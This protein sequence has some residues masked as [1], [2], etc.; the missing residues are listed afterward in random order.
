MA[1]IQEP[2]DSFERCHNPE[3]VPESVCVLCL[4]T[5]VAPTVEVLGQLGTPTRLPREAGACKETGVVRRNCIG[6]Q[7]IPWALESMR[8]S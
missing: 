2:Q 6:Q 7:L 8:S 3:D 4:H 5:I 1:K